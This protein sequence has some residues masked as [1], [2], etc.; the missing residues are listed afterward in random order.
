M[1]LYHLQISLYLSLSCDIYIATQGHWKNGPGAAF[2]QNDYIARFASFIMTCVSLD[3]Y[4]DLYAL[5]HMCSAVPGEL[6]SKLIRHKSHTC[7]AGYL[8]KM[9]KCFSLLIMHYGKSVL[10]S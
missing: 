3:L 6:Q 10:R 1:S 4:L 8:R 9:F 7:G 2:L 5:L